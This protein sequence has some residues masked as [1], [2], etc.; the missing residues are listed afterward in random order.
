[1][2]TERSL[3]LHF[4]R[5]VAAI[6]VC[7]GHSKEFIFLDRQPSDGFLSLAIRALLSLGSPSVLVFFFISG[8]LVGGR[9]IHNFRF[10][11]I[12]P[13]IFI[14][15]RLSRLWVVIIPALFF[16]FLVNSITC[17][18]IGYD[19][20][21]NNN[22]SLNFDL[23]SPQNSQGFADF[24]RNIF[25]LQD[26][27]GPV[28]GSNGPMWSM[29]YEFWYY[30]IFYSF[31]I[32]LWSLKMRRFVFWQILFALFF[33]LLGVNIL[34]LDW[35]HLGFVWLVGALSAEFSF[36]I[37]FLKSTKSKIVLPRI[38]LVFICTVLPFMLI[39]RVYVNFY[40]V[41][42]ICLSLYLSISLMD[43][44]LLLKT[45]S[46]KSILLLSS[47]SFS[48]YLIH[49]PLLA[50]LSAFFR[51]KQDIPL[52]ML[53]LGWIILFTFFSIC[54]SLIFAKSTEL[55]LD[56]VRKFLNYRT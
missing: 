41:V 55:K 10:S 39:N 15:D 9:E 51:M 12:N 1:V 25:F 42:A 50:C 11:S 27:M 21:C 54:I 20:F 43:S 37:Y 49:F 23:V 7:V 8:Y 6:L 38:F 40:S 32:I 4:I 29:S 47:I 18:V 28:W 46:F 30:M 14:V 33:F 45:H 44:K 2:L 52:N 5:A 34:T 31:I 26:F 22:R 17:S 56:S 36:D 48:L 53:S 3:Y 16:V 35:V 19:S 24:F 13:H